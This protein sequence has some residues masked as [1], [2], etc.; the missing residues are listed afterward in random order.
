MNY[1]N[2]RLVMVSI[3]LLLSTTLSANKPVWAENGKNPS[4][5]EKRKHKEDMTSKNKDKKYE[6]SYK[7]D[8]QHSDSSDTSDRKQHDTYYDK[9][10][11]G[12]G[13]TDKEFIEEKTDETKKNWI[14]KFF[15]FLN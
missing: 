9:K 10:Y 6:K 12:Q 11:E 7:E 1:K 5:Y 3:I 15:D 14:G 4:D 2:K 8:K 13:Q